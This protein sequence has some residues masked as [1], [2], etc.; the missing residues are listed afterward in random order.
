M[1]EKM[2]GM[3]GFWDC[4]NMISRHGNLIPSPSWFT[5]ELPM[6]ITLDGEL[7]MGPGTTHEK[8]MKVLKS[9][10]A[11]W[12]QIGYYL[13]DIPSCTGTYEERMEKLENLKEILP[14]HV[15]LVANIQCTGNA[16]LNEYLD[17]IIAAKGEGIMLRKP[18]TIYEVGYTASIL[19]VKVIQQ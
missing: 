15:R 10:T 1:S 9:K 8:F 12:G 14:S 3:R 2:D 13:F 11:D 17:S 19:K 16:H 6:D 5:S 7:W 4:H 18:N